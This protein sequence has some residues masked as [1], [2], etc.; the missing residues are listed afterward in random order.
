M[1]CNNQ[2]VL[3]C[4]VDNVVTLSTERLLDCYQLDTG[5]FSTEKLRGKVLHDSKE[6][7]PLWNDSQILYQF[8]Q[9]YF[10]GKSLPHEYAVLALKDLSNYYDIVFY[11]MHH[12]LG[13]EYK[14]NFLQHYFPFAK[15][16]VF[17]NST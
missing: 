3:L 6:L 11:T 12:L 13:R 2:P 8:E 4:D 16:I 1:I 15:K 10:Y 5:D 14:T 17:C 9:A 7:F